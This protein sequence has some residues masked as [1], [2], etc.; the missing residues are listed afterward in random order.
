MAEAEEGGDLL[1]RVLDNALR[2]RLP[3]LFKAAAV[4]V[5]E[6]RLYDGG[7]F[8][9]GR[10][11]VSYIEAPDEFIDPIAEYGGIF[12]GLFAGSCQ[13]RGGVSLTAIDRGYRRDLCAVG[14]GVFRGQAAMD[15]FWKRLAYFLDQAA[16]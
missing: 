10:G 4:R 8:L 15:L 6:S 1:S 16:M 9:S 14:T 13:E 7:S 2:V 5:F 12:E 11:L 3:D